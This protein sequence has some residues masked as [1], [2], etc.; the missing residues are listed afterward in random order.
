MRVTAIKTADQNALYF[1]TWIVVDQP[2][3]VGRSVGY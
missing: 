1:L 3:Q 2:A